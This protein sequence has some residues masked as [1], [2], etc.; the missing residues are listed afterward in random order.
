MFITIQ[1]RCSGAVIHQ[2]KKKIMEGF[3][4]VQTYR[5]Y[6]INLVLVIVETQ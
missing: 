3:R 1:P 6:F 5:K 4:E 2:K